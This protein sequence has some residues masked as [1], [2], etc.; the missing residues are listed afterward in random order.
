[1]NKPR[2][3]LDEPLR[4]DAERWRRLVEALPQLVWSATPDGVCDYF[5]A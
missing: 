3:I 1:M 5:S 2:R 4:K